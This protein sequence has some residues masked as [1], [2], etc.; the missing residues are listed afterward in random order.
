MVTILK[1]DFTEKQ[2]KLTIRTAWKSMGN[3]LYS[4]CQDSK[5]INA[6]IKTKLSQLICDE[7]ARQQIVPFL[8]NFSSGE[9]ELY[10]DEG[11][12]IELAELIADMNPEDYNMLLE[13][14]KNVE[15]S[16]NESIQ[17]ENDPIGENFDKALEACKK[18]NEDLGERTFDE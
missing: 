11:N 6:V 3:E 4:L 9:F 18:L 8:S 7:Y 2:R 5:Q 16:F 15:E 17:E 13:Q 12:A 1:E 10:F 14:A